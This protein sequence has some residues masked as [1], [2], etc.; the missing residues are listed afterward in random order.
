MGNPLSRRSGVK[1][2]AGFPPSAP[3]TPKYFVMFKAV[4]KN[5]RQVKAKEN[6]NRIRVQLFGGGLNLR[7][8]LFLE[9][10]IIPSKTILTPQIVNPPGVAI[11][12]IS[13]TPRRLFIERG[14]SVI[15]GGGALY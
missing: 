13:R 12:S 3:S 9:S 10:K 7:D 8:P 2:T 1:W 6:A 4:P 14:G 15:F 11:G 5:S